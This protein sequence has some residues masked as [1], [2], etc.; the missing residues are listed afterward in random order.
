METVLVSPKK[1]VLEKSLRL[2]FLAI[3][4]EAEYEALLAEMAMVAKL[5]GKVV[6]VYSDSRL[7]IRQVNGEFKAREPQMQEYL[8]KVRH[9]QSCFNNFT[10][11]QIP[12]GQNSHA[13]S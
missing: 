11:R 1:L 10:L 7:V 4:N 5:G 9:V 2:A 3:N 8:D 6:E 12:R 13:N